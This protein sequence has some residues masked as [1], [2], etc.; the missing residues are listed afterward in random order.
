MA[1]ALTQMRQQM[2]MQMQMWMRMRKVSVV[3][4]ARPCAGYSS[5][6]PLPLQHLVMSDQPLRRTMTAP[7]SVYGP[8]QQW[9]RRM[10]NHN[11]RK[12]KRKPKSK[13]RTQHFDPVLYL[14]SAIAMG[15]PEYMQTDS[16]LQ[17][18]AKLLRT[19]HAYPKGRLHENLVETATPEIAFIGR[20]NVG[21]SSLINGLL[22]HHGIAKSSKTPGR[23]Q[24]VDFFS[25][26]C[27]IEKD[28]EPSAPEVYLVDL[29]GYGYATA[30]LERKEMFQE[31][32]IRYLIER[33][34]Q[35][36][37]LVMVLI[38]SRRGIK[39][40]DKELIGILQEDNIEHQIVLT[41]ADAVKVEQ[42]A[43]VAT[44]TLDQLM[45]GSRRGCSPMLHICSSK[46][47]HGLAEL[48]VRIAAAAFALEV[49]DYEDE[50]YDDDDDDLM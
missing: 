35:A 18:V 3:L 5:M 24:S 14:P 23:T 38:D 32:A 27:I 25:A 34:P 17:R 39:G 49:E 29:P 41:K 48:R 40:I 43:K 16:E 47:S 10:A 42:L 20:S 11:P 33:S 28:G 13:N 36:L 9:V 37:R 1:Y 4:Q 46:D 31:E 50:D 22:N 7:W 2:Q 21:K 15:I 12:R 30:K 8:Q 26:G 45:R 44:E 19:G 6:T